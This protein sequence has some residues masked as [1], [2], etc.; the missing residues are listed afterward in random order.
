ML[1]RNSITGG[2]GGNVLS[3]SG[4]IQKS[5]NFRESAQP[6]EESLQKYFIC[7]M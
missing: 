5:M 2:K 4:L 1:T 6:S 3:P 7:I